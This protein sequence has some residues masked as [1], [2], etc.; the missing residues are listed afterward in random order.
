MAT[1][2]TCGKCAAGIAPADVNIAADTAYCRACGSLSR[3]SVMLADGD[4][5]IDPRAADDVPP[6]CRV[7]EGR[8]YGTTLR[9]TSRSLGTAVGL[10]FVTL[11]W[12][13]IVSVFVSFAVAGTLRLAGVRLPSWFP[14]PDAHKGNG[15][16]TT[17]GAMT[18][19]WLSLTPF[20]LIGSAMAIALAVSLLGHVSVRVG[21][22]GGR[23][24]TGIGPIGW[25]RRFDPAAVES[26]TVG[27]TAW[28]T[29]GQN[30]PTIVIARRPGGPLRFGSM[31]RDDRRAWL[32]AAMRRALAERAG[33]RR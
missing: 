26:V 22:D 23:A 11:F 14:A 9:S 12:N 10:L 1:R 19:L 21:P 6:G 7:V 8:G 31:L 13:G 5:G 18:F 25:P 4:A 32:V 17:V 16:G 15:F 2:V 33:R 20:I 27:K 3:P 30:Q 29:N 24:F 28:Q